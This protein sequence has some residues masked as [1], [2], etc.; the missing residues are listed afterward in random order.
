MTKEMGRGGGREWESERMCDLLCDRDPQQTCVELQLKGKPE[1]DFFINYF[2]SF[3][4]TFCFFKSRF[5]FVYFF[6]FKKLL[7]CQT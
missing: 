5:L 6:F 3:C 4:R 7:S 2:S 1:R